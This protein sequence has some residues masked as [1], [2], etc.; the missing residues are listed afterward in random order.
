MDPSALEGSILNGHHMPPLLL[1]Q[2]IDPF[3]HGE[4]V[5]LFRTDMLMTALSSKSYLFQRNVRGRSPDLILEQL[6]QTFI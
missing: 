6:C 4:H 5:G 1:H 3:L 2:G